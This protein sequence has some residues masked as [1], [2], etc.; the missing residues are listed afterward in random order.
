MR[1]GSAASIAAVLSAFSPNATPK[2]QDAGINEKEKVL[3]VRMEKLQGRCPRV[4]KSGKDG[5][6]EPHLRLLQIC[7][8]MAF[9]KQGVNFGKV[10]IGW[11]PLPFQKTIHA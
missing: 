11:F 6:I 7:R 8:F 5:C 1:S 9:G 10:R 3:Q 2:S 4:S